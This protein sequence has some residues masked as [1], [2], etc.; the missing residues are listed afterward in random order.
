MLAERTIATR[1]R[2]HMKITNAR[3]TVHRFGLSARG[4]D[5]RFH[6]ADRLRE[7]RRARIVGIG[8]DI[9]VP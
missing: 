3:R 4:D 6:L 2:C 8:A 7:A 9:T 5:Q 1:R